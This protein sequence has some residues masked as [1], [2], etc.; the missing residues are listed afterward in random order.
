MV[1]EQGNVGFGIE[2]SD[3]LIDEK[4]KGKKS[5]ARIGCSGR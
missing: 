3:S 1:A 5:D 2:V 4:N